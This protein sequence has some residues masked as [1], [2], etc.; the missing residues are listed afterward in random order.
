MIWI[1]IAVA[2]VVAILVIGKLMSRNQQNKAPKKLEEAK[3]AY[4]NQEI[5]MVYAALADAFYVPFNEV[6]EAEDAK[7]ALE[8]IELL[9]K[10]GK[11]NHGDF[12]DVIDKIKPFL[13]KA[14]VSG[15]KVP[16]KFTEPIEDI[17]EKRSEGAYVADSDAKP[18]M[19]VNL[20]AK[21]VNNGGSLKGKIKLTG[22]KKDVEL[23]YFIISLERYNRDS[24]DYEAEL[25]SQSPTYF[26]K[27]LAVGQE[28][29]IDFELFLEYEDFNLN[30][31]GL[32]KLMVELNLQ[33]GN[34]FNKKFEIKV[35]EEKADESKAYLNDSYLTDQ[36][37]EGSLIHYG[38][39]SCSL[40]EVEGG[41][42]ISW[43]DMISMRDHSGSQKWFKYGT[44]SQVAVSVD[45][46]KF[47]NIG[48]YGNTMHTYSVETG[49]EI[50]STDFSWEVDYI[51]WAENHIVCCDSSSILI[52]DSN[53]DLQDY[54]D[55]FSKL[56]DS[57]ISTLHLAKDKSKV[58]VNLDSTDLLL[59]FDPA[60][61]ATKEINRGE[62]Y[63]EYIQ[64]SNDD[65]FVCAIEANGLQVY[66]GS[67]N[68]LYE[69]RPHGKRYIRSKS[70]ADEG[71]Y[72]IRQ[73]ASLHPETK[74]ILY[75][76]ESG[77]LFVGDLVAKDYETIERSEV[78]FVLRAVWSNNQIAAISGQGE[79]LII[80]GEGKVTQREMD[81]ISRDERYD[82]DSDDELF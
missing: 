66:D 56:T 63:L 41:T 33:S 30:P 20:E 45:K 68:L 39:K 13:K 12:Q 37:L 31:N 1:I 5:D 7:I 35:L 38:D 14:A 25:G 17:L 81:F 62:S 2:V 55:N 22:A 71:Q 51:V 52:L 47:V 15:G 19:T 74:K 4:K 60:T 34:F 57:S 73:F 65:E 75:N 64:F 8:V 53:L 48:P 79:F 18:E 29:E 67:F 77:K 78:E 32:Y 23:H 43:G 72:L 61:K 59:E 76:N 58:L 11:E 70:R 16:D 26:A 54:L 28:M 21:T 46:T 10:V 49:E 80:S 50:I 27:K 9:E 44:G 82:E 42:L 3:E 40:F 6:Y 24:G 36:K 69:V